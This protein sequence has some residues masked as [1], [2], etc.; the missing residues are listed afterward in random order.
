MT[1]L[2]KF[3]LDTNILVSALIIRGSVSNRALAYCIEKGVL[4]FSSKTFDEFKQVLLRKKFRKY[5]SETEI[6]Q[7]LTKFIDISDFKSVSSDYK[8]CRDINDDMFLNLALDGKACCILSGD[9]DLL[10]I[11]PFRN[12]PILNS[13]QFLIYFGGFNDGI[14]LNEPQVIYGER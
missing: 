9:E 8:I 2:K 10:V 3:V 7:I 12:I 1:N 11:S 5:L 14:N 6:T 13:R 4:L